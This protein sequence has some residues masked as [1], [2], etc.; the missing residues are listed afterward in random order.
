MPNPWDRGSAVILERLGYQALASSSAG[1]AFTQ[2]LPDSVEALSVEAVLRHLADLVEATTLPINADFQQ[3]YAPDAEGV[4]KNVRRCV[5]TGVAGLS[6]EDATG[7][8]ATPLFPLE[9]AV[10]R[11]KAA[12][13]AIDASGSGVLLTARAECFLVNHKTPLEESIRRLKAYAK[14]GADVL[15]APGPRD[16]ASIQAL[17]QAVSPKPLNVVIGGPAPLKVADLTT[18]GVRRISTGGALARVAWTAVERAA[19]LLTE[20]GDFSIFENILSTPALSEKFSQVAT[21]EIKK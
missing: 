5:E 19:K 2:A 13:E 9:V 10:E 16:A 6:I 7:D 4:A 21:R 17:V 20:T 3:G 1:Y 14:A 12:R 15:F 18:L 11:L 8:A